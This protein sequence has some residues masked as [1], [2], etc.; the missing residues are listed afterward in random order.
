MAALDRGMTNLDLS[1]V[2]AFIALPL[3]SS[4]FSWRCWAGSLGAVVS[5][6]Q[7]QHRSSVNTAH[8]YG[9]QEMMRGA[10]SDNLA[11]IERCLAEGTS[12]NA[13]NPIGQTALHIA[14][15]W[16]NVKVA[17]VLI[18]AGAEV[19]PANQYG[20]TPLHFAAQ[21]GH[22]EFCQLLVGRGADLTARNLNGVMAWETAPGELR[23]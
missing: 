17:T 10:A 7:C 22:V 8:V 1:Q 3:H 16:N 14:A 19:S 20:A 11:A 21:K 15:I 13:V 18:D 12:P 4:R 6:P 23:P 9:S 5:T 2:F